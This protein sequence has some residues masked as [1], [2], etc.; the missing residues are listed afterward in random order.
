MRPKERAD[1]VRLLAALMLAARPGSAARHRN[2]VLNSALAETLPMAEVT[3][4]NP[5][6]GNEPDE[7]A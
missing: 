1:A 3:N 4:G 2:E 6:T 5:H 7:A